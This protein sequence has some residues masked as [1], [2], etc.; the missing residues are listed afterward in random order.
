MTRRTKSAPA[1]ALPAVAAI[2][3]NHVP[4]RLAALQSADMAELRAQW[5]SLFGTEPP[6]YSRRFM[7]ARLGYRIQELAYGG[8][9]LETLARLEAIAEAV[10]GKKRPLHLEE[11]LAVAAINRERLTPERAARVE[12]LHGDGVAPL[13]TAGV[14]A[15]VIV[16][17][18]PYISPEERD[19]LPASVREWEPALALFA[20]D[21]GM[22]VIA[23]LA[24]GAAR[25]AAPGALLALE[26]DSRRAGRAAELVTAA[27]VW[28]DVVVRPDLT[29]RA[30]FVLARRA[31]E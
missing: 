8:L 24:A 7:T 30:R 11:A 26:V 27:N 10:D 12:F 4:G 20:A 23:Q 2:P 17:N 15:S 28:R 31:E 3:P 14:R 16:S 21:E 22:A 18:P 9:R 6:A 13:E 5:R 29:G 1:A 19:E 25:I